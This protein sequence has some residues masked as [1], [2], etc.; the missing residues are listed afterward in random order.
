MKWPGGVAALL[1]W[2]VLCLG[3]V[4]AYLH[5]PPHTQNDHAP[6]PR[7]PAMNSPVAVIHNVAGLTLAKSLTIT[8]SNTY[9]L[10]AV[11]MTAAFIAFFQTNRQIQKI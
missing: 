4:G 9:S 2:H 6:K 1:M 3:L 8:T 10:A 5:M 11:N 7:H